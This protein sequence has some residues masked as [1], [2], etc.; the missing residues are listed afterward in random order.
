MNCAVLPS[1][2]ESVSH[3]PWG[4]MHFVGTPYG[5]MGTLEPND[6]R[7]AC[8]SSREGISSGGRNVFIVEPLRF[9][10]RSAFASR[11]V[12][13]SFFFCRRLNAK[14]RS[15]SAPGEALKARYFIP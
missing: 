2:Q 4:S 11:L 7:G 13:S 15:A 6:T 8:I 1:F 9:L 12:V 3:R 10:Y 5:N 14:T